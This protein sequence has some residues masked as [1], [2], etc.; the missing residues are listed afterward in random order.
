MAGRSLYLLIGL[1]IAIFS[2]SSQDKTAAPHKKPAPL[3][4]VKPKLKVMTAA[5]RSE[6]GFPPELIAQVEEAAKAPA[7]PFYEEVMMRSENLKGDVMI[8]SAKLSGFSVRTQDA[9]RLIEVLSAP[10][11]KDGFLIF[12]SQHNIGSVPDVVTV[13]R[14]N[15]SYDILLIQKTESPRH[16][17]DT[18][19]I[20]A[21]LRKQQKLGSFVITGAGADWL[22]ARFIV[23][24]KNMNGFARSVASFAPEVLA[25][26]KGT[27]EKL[28]DTMRR[29]N[30]FALWWD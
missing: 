29:T 27:I 7:E 8:A 17:L 5:Q 4:I 22:E 25:E 16:N 1:T 11:R 13:V 10:F 19:K 14:G 18:M 9:D 23:P 3:V 26:N 28:A 12:R 15:S 6:L 20:I 21:W 24:P 30:G 2:C